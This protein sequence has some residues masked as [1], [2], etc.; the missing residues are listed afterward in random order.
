MN[1]YALGESIPNIITM[2]FWDVYMSIGGS[3]V[4]IGLLIAMFI[5]GKR[6]DLRKDYKDFVWSR[7][8]QYQ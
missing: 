5:A 6:E 2:P 7:H 3:G 1:A 8:L 4:T